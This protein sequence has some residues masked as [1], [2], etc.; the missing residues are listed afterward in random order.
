MRDNQVRQRLNVALGYR[1]IG[2]TNDTTQQSGQTPDME[3]EIKNIT[4][5]RNYCNLRHSVI[6]KFH[7]PLGL[8]YTLKICHYRGRWKRGVQLMKI[9]DVECND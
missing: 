9:G 6:P 8:F 7:K 5:Y 1:Y 4:V 3:V 2:A